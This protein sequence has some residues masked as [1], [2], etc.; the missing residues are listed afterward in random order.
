MANKDSANK[1]FCVGV[2]EIKTDRWEPMYVV[3]Q[4]WRPFIGSNNNTDALLNSV[5]WYDVANIYTCCAIR[6]YSQ[7]SLGV[8]W[9]RKHGYN[10]WNFVAVMYASWYIH[11]VYLL[12]VNGRHLWFPLNFQS[13][14]LGFLTSAYSLAAYHHCYNTNAHEYSGVAVTILFLG[15]S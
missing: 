8:V 4:R 11:T 14:H 1:V 13:R 9:P 2:L 7:W 5:S 12:P 10:R 3:N 15:A 6:Q